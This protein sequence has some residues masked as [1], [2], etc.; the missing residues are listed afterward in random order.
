L[1]VLSSDRV[2][3]ALLENPIWRRVLPKIDDILPAAG[4]GRTVRGA[5][6]VLGVIGRVLG[7][8]MDSTRSEPRVFREWERYL[9]DFSTP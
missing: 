4:S 2:I 3:T 7:L 9:D 6:E 8:R 5:Q 1:T